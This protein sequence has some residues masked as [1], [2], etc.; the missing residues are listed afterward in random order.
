MTMMTYE[1]VKQTQV[2]ELTTKSIAATNIDI[3][4]F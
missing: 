1:N 2:Q 3:I 4:T